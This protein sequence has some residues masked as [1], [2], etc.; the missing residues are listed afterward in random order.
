MIYRLVQQ[1]RSQSVKQTPVPSS[2]DAR[3]QDVQLE[4][5]C[6]IHT[7]MEVF[8]DFEA[9]VYP[10]MPLVHLPTMKAQIAREEYRT[11]PPLLRQC[12]AMAAA[13]VAS[14]PR[15]L[16]LYARNTGYKSVS[17]FVGRAIQLVQSSR[18]M[19]APMYVS[20]PNTEHLT[21]SMMLSLA[22]HYTTDMMNHAWLYTNEVSIFSRSMRLGERQGYADLSLIECELRKR[23][24]WCCY[25]I[26]M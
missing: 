2:P 15:K 22:A 25:I 26:Q 3:E 18:V 1:A 13:T 14:L 5:F 12:I 4:Q 8:E 20:N 6:S 19:D 16:S 17:S 24:F 23:A 7:F 9:L 10:V 11:N 21:T